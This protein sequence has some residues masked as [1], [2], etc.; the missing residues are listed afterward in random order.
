MGLGLMAAAVLTGVFGWG[1]EARFYERW[2]R[3]LQKE[4]PSPKAHSGVAVA[5]QIELAVSFFSPQ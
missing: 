3:S 1:A 4:S 2:A 5:R